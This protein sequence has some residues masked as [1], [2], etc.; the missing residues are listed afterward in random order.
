MATFVVCHKHLTKYP[1]R[2][3][4]D[5]LGWPA[6]LKLLHGVNGRY[7]LFY[8]RDGLMSLDTHQATRPVFF[9][10]TKIL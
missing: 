3:S 4:H 5:Q 6:D 1:C 10:L 2:Q 9:I 8:V 7:L